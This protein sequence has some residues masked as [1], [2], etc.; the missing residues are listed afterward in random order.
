MW[1]TVTNKYSKTEF[2]IGGIVVEVYNLELLSQYEVKH[3]D[4]ETV[5]ANVLYL[6]HGRTRSSSDSVSYGEIAANT[7][8]EKT[9]SSTPF[10]FVTFDCPNHGKRLTNEVTN[11]DWAGGNKSHAV[12]MISI[13]DA[14]VDELKLIIDYLPSYLRMNGINKNLQL[15][16]IVSGVSLGG[17]TVYRFALKYPESVDILNPVIGCNNLTSLMVD[18]LLKVDA[19]V[20]S[21]WYLKEYEELNLGGSAELYPKAFHNHLKEIDTKIINEFPFTKKCFAAFGKEDPLV[22]NIYSMGFLE[23]YQ[24]QN[25]SVEIFREEGKKHVVTDLMITNFVEWLVD[26]L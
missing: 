24:Q 15:T 10:I 17:H 4:H 19:E 9:K 1:P 26:V 18:R 16:T 23:K 25:P 21:K 6:V 5:P 22:P 12:D 14:T 11:L 7:Y 8:Y 20:D 2:T 13:V 3:L